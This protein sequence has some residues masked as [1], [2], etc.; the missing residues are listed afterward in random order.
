V[1]RVFDEGGFVHKGILSPGALHR[2]AERLLL[3]IRRIII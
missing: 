2:T 1:L 3:N